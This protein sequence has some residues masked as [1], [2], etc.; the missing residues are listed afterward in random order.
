LNLRLSAINS[1][2]PQSIRRWK[3]RQLAEAT[4]KA[5][6]VEPPD[7]RGLSFDGALQ[8]YAIFTRN[9]ALRSNV[10]S[11]RRSFIKSRLFECGRQMGAELRQMLRVRTR[12]DVVDAARILYRLL[13]IDFRGEEGDGFS[14]KQCSFSKFYTD[15]VCKIVSSLDEG[16]IAGL[17]DG[18]ELRFS[19]MMTEGQDM[20]SGSI[21][22]KGTTDETRNRGGHRCRWCNRG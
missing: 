20:C 9:E 3:F 8:S 2:I 17:S 5:F 19:N 11:D 15:D 13:G 6:G 1:Y 22:F 14:I 18:A 16:L 4:A 12:Q 21:T 10:H 7:L